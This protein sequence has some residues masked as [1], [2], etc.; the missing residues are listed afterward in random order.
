MGQKHDHVL[1]QPTRRPTHLA[2]GKLKKKNS[3]HHHHHRTQCDAKIEK[4]DQQKE[5]D[6]NG[7]TIHAKSIQVYS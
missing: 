1:L 2:R 4:G 6:G 5:K 3:N 7:E